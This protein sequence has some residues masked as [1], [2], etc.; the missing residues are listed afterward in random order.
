MAASGNGE[1][2]GSANATAAA[3]SRPVADHRY[4]RPHRPLAVRAANGAGRVLSL[5]GHHALSLDPADMLRAASAARDLHDF[6]TEEFREP[7]EVL[8][9]SLDQQARLTPVGRFFG[10]GRIVDALRN[11]LD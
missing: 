10:R 5:T 11:R 7:M 4:V 1:R 6:G 8:A 3:E 9:S 2:T